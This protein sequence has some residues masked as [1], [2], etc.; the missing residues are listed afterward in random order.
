MTPW[1]H[2]LFVYFLWRFSPRFSCFSVISAR[3]GRL[4]L[5]LGLASS[6]RPNVIY[7]YL[8]RTHKPPTFT[9]TV[10]HSRA[11]DNRFYFFGHRNSY[12]PSAVF[13]YYFCYA[14]SSSSLSFSL[15]LLLF[16]FL[17]FFCRISLAF[18]ATQGFN[19]HRVHCSSCFFSALSVSFSFSLRA[20]PTLG[21]NR[22]F[23][24]TSQ[25]RGSLAATSWLSARAASG[26]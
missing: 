18:F 19:S 13:Y 6:A 26:N 21:P 2:L 7:I 15:L 12:F 22:N 11:N 23:G 17:G 14:T 25:S 20:C 8:F 24:H 5:G 3:L 10:A 16:I 1:P 4:G 9:L